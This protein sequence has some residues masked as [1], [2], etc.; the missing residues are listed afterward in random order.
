MRNRLK[1]GR[2]RGFCG[3]GEWV[4]DAGFCEQM[5]GWINLRSSDDGWLAWRVRW[6]ELLRWIWASESCWGE[7]Q[8]GAWGF[9]MVMRELKEKGQEGEEGDR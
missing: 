8:L 9:G 7:G 5:R 3:E 6:L 1:M 4:H 2:P